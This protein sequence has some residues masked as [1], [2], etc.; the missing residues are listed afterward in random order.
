MRSFP[1]HPKTDF[2]KLKLHPDNDKSP[3]Y[4]KTSFFETR[5]TSRRFWVKKPR[6]SEK[7]NAEMCYLYRR[8]CR[9]AARVV[10]RSVPQRGH[11][12]GAQKKGI[13]LK[14]YY[15]KFFL[16]AGLPKP[17]CVELSIAAVRKP[18]T[19]SKKEHSAS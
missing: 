8:T 7:Q 19:S 16:M 6:Y 12:I 4:T 17:C 18:W 3:K 13:V 1:S 5:L 15:E 10:G 9:H 14:C 11:D 2:R